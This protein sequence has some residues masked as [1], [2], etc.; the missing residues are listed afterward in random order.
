MAYEIILPKSER[1]QRQLQRQSFALESLGGESDILRFQ[2]QEERDLFLEELR[3]QGVEAE[4]NVRFRADVISSADSV[5]LSLQAD[6]S[7]LDPGFQFQW[8]FYNPTVYASNRFYGGDIDWVRASRLSKG[9]GRLIVV[10]SGIDKNHMDLQGRVI[11]GYDAVANNNQ[12]VDENGHGTHVASIAAASENGFGIVGVAPGE[13]VEIVD[14]RMLGAD[15]SATTEQAIR[16]FSF[17][18]NHIETYFQQNSE[19][20]VV[21]NNSWG[22]PDFSAGLERAMARLGRFDRVLIVTSAGNDNRNNDQEGYWPCLSNLS[23]NICVGASD[24]SDFKT[25]FSSFGR[26]SVKILAPGQQIIGASLQN[27]GFVEK[28]GTSQAVPHVSGAALL[29]WD[30]NPSLKAADIKHILLQSVDRLPGAENEVRSAGRLNVYRAILMATGDDISLADRPFEQGN[31]TAGG[32][33]YL[34][35][36]KDLASESIGFWTLL[37][38]MSAFLGLLRSYRAKTT[39]AGV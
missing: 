10:D 19:G 7:Q 12:P 32:G 24:P 33:C 39:P 4:T 17:I 18:E 21:I 35:S 6:L 22:G 26:N 36:Q 34:R 29:I 37:I 16:A 38:F 8:S 13:N 2:S 14:V 27:S 23:N 31:K 3:A 9:R 20:F 5:S 11:A 25:S 28:S 30:A 1:S 15:N